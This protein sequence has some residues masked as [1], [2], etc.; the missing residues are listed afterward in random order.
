MDKSKRKKVITIGLISI[1]LIVTLS[2]LIKYG[3]KFLNIYFI[4]KEVQGIQYVDSVENFSIWFPDT[5]SIMIDTMDISDFLNEHPFLFIDNE[6]FLLNE[7]NPKILEKAKFYRKAYI[8]NIKKYGVERMFAVAVEG[9]IDTNL[10]ILFENLNQLP[11]AQEL[12]ENLEDLLNNYE[13][14]HIGTFFFLDTVYIDTLDSG[15]KAI[16]F[17]LSRFLIKGAAKGYFKIFTRNGKV[18][19][20]SYAYSIE[21]GYEHINYVDKFFNSFRFLDE[22]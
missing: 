13:L 10:N 6:L 1:Y 5:P 8:A 18:Y 20:L 17:S 16:N 7:L 22:K 19:V 11:T 9:F 2:L 14:A 4:D 12:K 15:I 3:T 21:S